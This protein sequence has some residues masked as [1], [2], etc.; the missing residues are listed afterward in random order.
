M[1][2]TSCV[3][4]LMDVGDNLTGHV[5]SLNPSCGKLGRKLCYG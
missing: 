4:T 5:G 1:T 2:E 3:I